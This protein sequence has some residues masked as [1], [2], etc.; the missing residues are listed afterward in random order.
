MSESAASGCTFTVELLGLGFDFGL[1]HGVGDGLAE[2]VWALAPPVDRGVVVLPCAVVL[3]AVLANCPVA[4]EPG[5]AGASDSLLGLLPVPVGAVLPESEGVGVGDGVVDGKVGVGVG[6]GVVD[7]G[8]VG[9]VD[10]GG[11]VVMVGRAVGFV[12]QIAE[13]GGLRMGI[14]PQIGPDCGWPKAWPAAEVAL[15][16]D[17]CG[18]PALCAARPGPETVDMTAGT[19]MAV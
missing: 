9:D 8:G 11:G 18:P 12:V 16:E 4:P 5:S 7:G 1:T 14:G 13:F 6:G 19:S 15:P 2:M 17:G 10:A 3:L